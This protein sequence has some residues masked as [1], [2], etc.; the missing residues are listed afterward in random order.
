MMVP[1]LLAGL[2]GGRGCG[3]AQVQK[4]CATVLA[5]TEKKITAAKEEISSGAEGMK[6]RSIPG[7]AWQR[8]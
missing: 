7:T 3:G 4:H 6:A 2:L 1:R 8:I 5:G